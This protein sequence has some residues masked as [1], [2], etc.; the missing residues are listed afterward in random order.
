MPRDLAGKGSAESGTCLWALHSLLWGRGLAAPTALTPR[1]GL[2]PGRH[3]DARGPARAQGLGHCADPTHTLPFLSVAVFPAAPSAP[4][5]K[6][7]GGSGCGTTQSPKGSV[8]STPAT[9]LFSPA[10]LGAR[11]R[12]PQP[13]SAPALP[14]HGRAVGPPCPIQAMPKCWSARPPPGWP[15]R[16]EGLGCPPARTAELCQVMCQAWGDV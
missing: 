11:W 2:G 5:Q 14:Q 13:W 4:S 6:P 10:S 7:W 16:A 9:H 15:G 8:P 1:A 12:W 3:Q